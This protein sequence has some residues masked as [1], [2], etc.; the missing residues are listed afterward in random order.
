MSEELLSKLSDLA[1]RLNLIGDK[2]DEP[3]VRQAISEV[4]WLREAAGKVIVNKPDGFPEIICLCG[5][6]RFYEQFMEANYKLTMAGKIVLSVGFFMHRPDTQ[7]GEIIG[8][9][10]EQ[11]VELDKLHLRKIELS[12]CVVVL[13]VEGYIG[14]STRKEIE[15]AESIGKPVAYLESLQD[16]PKQSSPS[17]RKE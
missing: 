11:K 3:T 4:K 16:N 9:T 8:C 17:P 5:S 14:E 13:N 2:T 10:P 12:D 6:T 7:Y 1:Q 15:Y